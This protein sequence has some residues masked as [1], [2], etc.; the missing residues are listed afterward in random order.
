MGRA[1]AE[2]AMAQHSGERGPLR[3]AGAPAGTHQLR[4]VL[5]ARHLHASQSAGAE[6]GEA[7]QVVGACRRGGGRACAQRDG[8]RRGST[9][10]RGRRPLSRKPIISRYQRGPASISSSGS[11]CVRIS[12]STIPAISGIAVALSIV[13]TRHCN[14]QVNTCIDNIVSTCVRTV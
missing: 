12:H 1:A 9:G 13:G 3:R 8:Y 7:C 14:K 6:L 10:I 11:R 2:G 5:W 4:I